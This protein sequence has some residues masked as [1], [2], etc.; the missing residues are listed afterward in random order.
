MKL[1][2]MLSVVAFFACIA[3]CCSC[4]NGGK[5]GDVM[6]EW[7]GGKVIVSEYVQTYRQE[8]GML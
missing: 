2:K 6:E 5:D 1:R 4:A 3:G 7:K 8:E